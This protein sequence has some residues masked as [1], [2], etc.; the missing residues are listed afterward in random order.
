MQLAE[1]ET[2]TAFTQRITNELVRIFKRYPSQWML[3]YPRW[4]RI[5][6]GVPAEGFPFYSKPLEKHP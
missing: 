1:G 2:D 4:M 5:P 3:M 6:P